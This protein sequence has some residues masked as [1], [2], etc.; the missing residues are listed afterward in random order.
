MKRVLFKHFAVQVDSV[1]EFIQLGSTLFKDS[2]T[3]AP[4]LAD[5]PF[6]WKSNSTPSKSGSGLSDLDPLICCTIWRCL[7]FE[8]Q[9]LRNQVPY[10][11][12]SIFFVTY[13]SAQ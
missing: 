10:S 4:K 6:W 12:H 1:I 11:Q 13:E 7:L 8:I 2:A 9:L 5:P 3:L